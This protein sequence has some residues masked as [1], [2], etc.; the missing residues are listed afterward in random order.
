ML[1]ITDLLLDQAQS[2]IEQITEFEDL[3]RSLL[4][5]KNRLAEA[6]CNDEQKTRLNDIYELRKDALK[7]E[8][9]ENIDRFLSSWPA[10]PKSRNIGTV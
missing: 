9:L 1:Q 7:Q 4:E 8:K 2:Q 3:Q 6:E 10:N 5:L